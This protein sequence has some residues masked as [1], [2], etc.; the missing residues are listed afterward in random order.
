[1]KGQN[2]HNGG[3]GHPAF[4]G[5]QTPIFR[6]IPK[7]GFTNISTKEYIIFN[8]MSININLMQY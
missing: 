6:R 8:M 3:G 4:E 1:M 2:A 7:V 5:V